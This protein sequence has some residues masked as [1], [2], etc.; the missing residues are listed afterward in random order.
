MAANLQKNTMEISKQSLNSSSNQLGIEYMMRIRGLC[1][2]KKI[3]SYETYKTRQWDTLSQLV[4]FLHEQG[5]F[6]LFLDVLQ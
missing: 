1:K 2:K 5:R 4:A 6:R 3:Q